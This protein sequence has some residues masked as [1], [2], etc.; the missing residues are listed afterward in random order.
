[1]LILTLRVILIGKLLNCWHAKYEIEI[2]RGDAT[3]VRNCELVGLPDLNTER[4]NV[5][6]SLIDYMN[7]LIDLGVGKNF[8]FS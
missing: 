4:S 1:M 5:Q 3:S 6:Q 8:K 7:H 2:F